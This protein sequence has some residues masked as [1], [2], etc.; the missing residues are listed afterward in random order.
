MHA[1]ELEKGQAVGQSTL[2]A[3]Y[4]GSGPDLESFNLLIAA[5]GSLANRCGVHALLLGS[6]HTSSL[7]RRCLPPSPCDL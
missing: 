4:F 1:A 3:T 5:Y 6:F 2:L 7:V